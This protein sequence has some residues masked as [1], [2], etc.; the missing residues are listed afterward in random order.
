MRVVYLGGDPRKPSEGIGANKGATLGSWSTGVLR[1]SRESGKYVPELYHQGARQ[2]GC[3]IHQLPL[4]FDGELS[5]GVNSGA[6]CFA[7]NLALA[8]DHPRSEK[9]RK[10]RSAMDTGGPS[11]V[12]T[13]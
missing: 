7:P 2:P 1:P 8:R 9:N 5:C 13:V 11:A 3:L 6:F 12:A 10:P 4:L